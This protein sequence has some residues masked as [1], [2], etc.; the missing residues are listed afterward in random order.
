MQ[1]TYTELPRRY[2]FDV[3]MCHNTFIYLLYLLKFFI[4]YLYHVASNSKGFRG[5]L[6]SYLVPCSTV[7]RHCAL[8]L[9][10]YLS[11]PGTPSSVPY[12]PN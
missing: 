9:S 5:Q 7:P 12:M 4:S 6:F 11:P 3:M 10:W 8:K 1:K 2:T